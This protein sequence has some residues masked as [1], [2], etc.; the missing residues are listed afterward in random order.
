[1]PKIS[2]YIGRLAP[3]GKKALYMGYS[4]IPVFIGNVL[5]GIVSGSVYQQT[6][7]KVDIARRFATT[8]ELQIP[9]GLSTNAYFEEVAR[10]V[11]LTPQE[12][13]NLLWDTYHPSG[14]WMIL[15]GIGLLAVVALFIYDR[16]ISRKRYA[17][18]A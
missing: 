8:N 7:D 5:A 9:E 16:M 15:L 4:F 18:P 17:L 13:T 14:I 1:S 3:D 10:Q 6:S 12:L 2:E 11:N